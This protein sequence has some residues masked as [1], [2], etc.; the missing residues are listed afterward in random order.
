MKKYIFD[1]KI[2]I[3][4]HVGYI[5]MCNV[6]IEAEIKEQLN[7]QGYV[8]S[9]IKKVESYICTVTKVRNK[10]TRE[11]LQNTLTK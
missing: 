4:R 1:T 7:E 3:H 10:K 9:E 11:E 5:P 6:T 2:M 8:V